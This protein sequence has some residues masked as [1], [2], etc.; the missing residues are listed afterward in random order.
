L[1]IK[2][3]PLAVNIDRWIMGNL[4]TNVTTS[5]VRQNQLDATIQI[6]RNIA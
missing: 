1:I 2:A 3:H 4:V 6:A 5:E